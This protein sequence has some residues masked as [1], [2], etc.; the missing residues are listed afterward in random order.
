[1]RSTLFGVHVDETG[2]EVVVE[3]MSIGTLFSAIGSLLKIFPEMIKGVTDI[4]K[5]AIVI[6]KALVGALDQLK[7]GPVAFITAIFKVIIGGIVLIVLTIA[8]P[9]IH[10]IIFFWIGD[11]LP[12][13]RGSIRFNIGPP[14]TRTLSTKRC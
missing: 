5:T 3:E 12:R 6:V 11:A 8:K 4:V 9:W 1:M 14:S 2:R 13:A 10:F 7:N